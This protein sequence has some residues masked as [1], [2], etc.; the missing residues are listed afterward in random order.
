MS[1]VPV[2]VPAALAMAGLP[3]DYP[4]TEFDALVQL[5]VPVIT[6]ALRDEAITTTE[7]GVTATLLL[8]STEIVAGEWWARHARKPMFQ[9]SIGMGDLQVFPRRYDDVDDPTGLISKGWARLGPWRKS[10]ASGWT[11]TPVQSSAGKGRPTTEAEEG[12]A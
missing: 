10:L 7:A 1:F 12:S 3:P 11:P 8:A 4:T 5:L 2:S 6:Y 9:M